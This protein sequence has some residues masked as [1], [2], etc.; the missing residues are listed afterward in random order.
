[1]KKRS[2][3]SLIEI[4]IAILVV[5]A[6]IFGITQASS[7]IKKMRLNTARRITSSS[8]V[9]GI[10]DLILQI[11]ATSEGSFKD[12][13]D[14]DGKTITD[15]YDINPQ[16]SSKNNFTQSNSGFRPTYKENSI[17]G[18]P[19][20]YFNGSN[21]RMYNS[22]KNLST[23]FFTNNGDFTIFLVGNLLPQ[24][25]GTAVILQF[26][27]DGGGRMLGLEINNYTKLRMDSNQVNTGTSNIT[28][29]RNMVIS[30][31]SLSGKSTIFLNGAQYSAA[32]AADI[33]NVINGRF[34]IGYYLGTSQLFT[35]AYI[36]ELIVYG[37][38]LTTEERRSIESYLG[39]KW[40][41]KVS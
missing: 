20:I 7:L 25:Q 1:M 22:I 35:K 8:P 41:V 33:K 32:T 12:G 34:A 19:S 27:D 28:L 23:T 11:D 9:A 38:A 31:T 26:V 39:R 13:E 36:G 2:A 3:F 6:L 30:G 21:S 15:W 10:K 4:S 24:N 17:N 14:S 5:S 18:L 37:R 40:G 16:S 29:D